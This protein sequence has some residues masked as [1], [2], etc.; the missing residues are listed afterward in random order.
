V[1]LPHGPIAAGCH[2]NSCEGF[3]WP[4]LREHYE[5]GAYDRR[6]NDSAN[7][8]NTAKGDQNLNEE[9]EPWFP[10]AAFYSYQLPEFPRDVFPP[11]MSEYTAPLCACFHSGRLYRRVS[12]LQAVPEHVVA[13]VGEPGVCPSLKGGE[14]CVQVRELSG[15]VLSGFPIVS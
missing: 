4:E 13:L 3:G 9:P 5:P 10:P 1:R 2:H 15:E 11:W 6:K 12:V 8:A 14:L 7:N